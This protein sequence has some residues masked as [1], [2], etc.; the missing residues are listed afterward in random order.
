MVPL[1]TMRRRLHSFAGR[2]GILAWL[3]LASLV[4]H[5]TGLTE[6]VESV[7]SAEHDRDCEESCPGDAPDGECPP[8]CDACICCPSTLYV[9]APEL[10]HSGFPSIARVT[11]LPPSDSNP[12]GTSNTIFRPPRSVS[13]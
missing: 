7:A 2:F 6:L 10:L 3:L 4:V 13:A 5:Q 8:G 1:R 9:L 12:T 11:L